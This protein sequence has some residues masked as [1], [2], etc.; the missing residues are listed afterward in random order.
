MTEQNA[1]PTDNA[2][3]GANRVPVQAQG[4]ARQRFYPDLV[5]LR[6]MGR[7][8][9]LLFTWARTLSGA[10]DGGYWEFFTFPDDGAGYAVPRMASPVEVVVDG[11]GF[12]GELSAEAFGIVVSLFA[13]NHLAA[14][15]PDD[16]VVNRYYSLREFALQHA[17]A[18]VIAAAID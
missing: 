2:D 12:S 16:L 13:L 17:E 6:N 8:E 4:R 15:T 1:F 3:Q 7:F 11:N 14:L 5:G 18:A 9:S 10:Y